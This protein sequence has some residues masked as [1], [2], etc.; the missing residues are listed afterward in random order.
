MT[1]YKRFFEKLP[2][3]RMKTPP[4]VTIHQ[5]PRNRKL[6][7]AEIPGGD[8]GAKAIYQKITTPDGTTRYSGKASY[9]PQGKFKHGSTKK[10][11]VEGEE[12]PRYIYDENLFWHIIDKQ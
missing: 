2:S 10:W 7:Q 6:M 5:L 9:D 12:P 3:G 8:P 4:N 11:S 1:K